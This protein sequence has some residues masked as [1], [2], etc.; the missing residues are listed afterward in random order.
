M[1]GRRVVVADV[2]VVVVL[3]V[4][5][6]DRRLHASLLG[7]FRLRPPSLLHGVSVVALGSRVV[8]R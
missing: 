5:D 3:V 1:V 7:S 8:L 6:G 4:S 2:V